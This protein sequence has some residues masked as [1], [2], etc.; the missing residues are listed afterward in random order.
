MVRGI[1]QFKVHFEDFNDRYVLIGGAACFL[2]LEMTSRNIKTMSS[3]FS[4]LL[5]QTNELH[6]RR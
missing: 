3:G 2:A 4:K 1:D 5:N 6:C